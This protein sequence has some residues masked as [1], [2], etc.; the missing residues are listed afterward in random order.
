MGEL[1]RGSVITLAVA[2]AYLYIHQQVMPLRGIL[3]DDYYTAGIVGAVVAFIVEWLAKRW[4]KAPPAAETP[5]STSAATPTAKD[6][7]AQP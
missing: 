3:A 7:G 1:K 2:L 5:A 4:R 6:P